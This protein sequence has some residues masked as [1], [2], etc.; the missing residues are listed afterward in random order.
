M[1][2][3]HHAFTSLMG[4]AL[5]AAENDP[6]SHLLIIETLMGSVGKICNMTL[7]MHHYE[8]NSRTKDIFTNLIVELVSAML[9]DYLEL[10]K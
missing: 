2:F 1:K 4:E 10:S 7:A 3:D 6:A 8:E 9:R 5:L